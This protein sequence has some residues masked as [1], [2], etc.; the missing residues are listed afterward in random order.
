MPGKNELPPQRGLIERRRQGQ[1][2]SILS[3]EPKVSPNTPI[4]PPDDPKLRKIYDEL[5]GTVDSIAKIKKD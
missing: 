3:K 5:N 1:S 4:F 2:Q